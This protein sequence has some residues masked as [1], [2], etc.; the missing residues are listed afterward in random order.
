M[1]VYF[2]DKVGITIAGRAKTDFTPDMTMRDI[3]ASVGVPFRRFRTSR[4]RLLMYLLDMT[5]RSDKEKENLTKP[6]L[7]Y[8]ERNRLVRID[9][10]TSNVSI[11]VVTDENTHKR[12]F[13]IVKAN[14]K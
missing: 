9:D 4:G 8:I 7:V 5:G 1:G 3:L 14:S 12:H 10:W 2:R 11:S 13:M 6:L